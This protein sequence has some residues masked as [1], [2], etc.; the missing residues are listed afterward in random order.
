M[1][2]ESAHTAHNLSASDFLL[3]LSL[4][5]IVSKFFGEI[6]ERFKQ[7]AVLGELV[8]GVVL[9]AGALAIMPSSPADAGYQTFHLIAELAV[10]VLLF[11]IGLETKLK[12][13]LKVGPVS[14]LVALV[15]IVAPFALGFLC[16]YALAA[17]GIM[18]LG[19]ESVFLI[20][21][22]A[23]ATLTATSVGITARVLSD[24]RQL[25]S[26]EAKIV[27]GAAVI[28]DV[29]GLII[30]SLV[31][32]LIETQNMSAAGG[33]S[34]SQIAII[35]GK[36]FGFLFLAVVLG[37]LVVE[38]VFSFV[39][40][41]RS[42]GAMIVAALSVAFLYAYAGQYFAEV[43]PIVGAFAAGLV[44]RKTHHFEEIE[45]QLR[46]V[47][48]FLVPVFFVAVGAQVDVG[49]LNPFSEGNSAVLMVALVLFVVA[50]IG[51][52]ASAFAAFGSG[53][54]RNIVGIGMIPRGEVGLIFAQIGYN[55]G[56]GVFDSRFFSAI[57]LTVMLTTFVVPPLLQKGYGNPADEKGVES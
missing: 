29:V 38:R 13:I 54:R 40:K 4:V 21:V 45:S 52:Y 25:G 35:A 20:A 22:T 18:G 11:E 24:L 14:L 55:N 15:G 31:S 30:L 37:N 2:S 48:D 34:V 56:N 47:S 49:V 57:V 42:R 10:V 53:I 32:G 26:P 1:I 19:E 51:K 6:A 27:I 9:G 43:A 44:I 5:L 36:A 7:S 33:V 16:V 41:L 46:N 3:I 39:E 8:A 12:E 50:F 23:G 28:D 17:Y